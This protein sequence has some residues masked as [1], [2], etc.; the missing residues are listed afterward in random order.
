MPLTSPDLK[1]QGKERVFHEH[2]G[3][4]AVEEAVPA[5][6]R[7]EEGSSSTRDAELKHV[8]N[9]RKHPNFPAVSCGCP[10]WPNLTGSQL[11]QVPA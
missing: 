8:G 10:H 9:G 5:G 6:A 7:S 2:L 4:H 11:A 3:L 1:G